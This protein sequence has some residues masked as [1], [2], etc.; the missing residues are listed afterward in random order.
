LKRRS[1]PLPPLPHVV[2]W[3][4]EKLNWKPRLRSCS[5]FGVLGDRRACNGESVFPNSRSSLGSCNWRLESSESCA[6]GRQNRNRTGPEVEMVPDSSNSPFV[7]A[8][9][10]ATS[11]GNR[12]EC[13]RSFSNQ[14]QV[15]A[16]IGVVP[17]GVC[18]GRRGNSSD[19]SFFGQLTCSI[20][21]ALHCFA[22]GE[23]SR[24]KRKM[25]KS[26]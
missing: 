5:D 3:T 2:T 25:L 1:S 12:R 15:R 9:S 17:S 16:S 7:F 6:K 13:H 21:V 10:F 20:H 18:G 26:A 23:C 14:A 11:A 22:E 24:I 19:G 8:G 4:P